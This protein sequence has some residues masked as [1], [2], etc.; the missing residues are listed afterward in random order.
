MTPLIEVQ[1]V[2]KAFGGLQVIDDCS[3]RVEKG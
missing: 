2:N 1:Q 3:I